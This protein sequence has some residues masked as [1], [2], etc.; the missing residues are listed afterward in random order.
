MSNIHGLDSMN[1]G[2]SSDGSDGNNKGKSPGFY[3]GG[4]TNSGQEVLGPPGRDNAAFADRLFNAARNAGAQELPV[5]SSASATTS[6]T[7]PVV[8]IFNVWTNG[9]S[10][11]D[12]PL[13]TSDDPQNGAFMRALVTGRVPE[14]LAAVHPGR[15]IDLQLVRKESEYVAPKPKPFSGKFL[16]VVSAY[17]HEYER[18]II[19]IREVKSKRKFSFEDISNQDNDEEEDVLPIEEVCASEYSRKRADVYSEEIVRGKQKQVV[20]I[21]FEI[22]FDRDFCLRLYRVQPY[23]HPSIE[24]FLSSENMA[25]EIRTLLTVI[26]PSSCVFVPSLHLSAP[27]NE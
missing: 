24:S 3:V 20:A 19:Q 5:E 9:F 22:F 21:L 7:G 11:D 4:S 12:G 26:K 14:E 16:V 1:S 13:R 23:H 27:Q 15:E 10:I 6:Q 25:M 18:G 17:L 8:V 2:N